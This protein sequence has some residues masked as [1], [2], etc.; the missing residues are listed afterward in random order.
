MSFK[1]L[2]DRFPPADRQE[3]MPLQELLTVVVRSVGERTTGAC[4]NLLS[5]LVPSEQIILVREVPFSRAMRRG[6]EAALE[7]GRKWTLVVDADTLV[8]PGFAQEITLFAQ[9]QQA[10]AFVVQGVVFDKFFNLLRPAGNHLYRT[11]HLQ[12]ALECI[13]EEGCTLRPETHMIG[14]MVR[15]GYLFIQKPFLAGLHDFEQQYLDIARKCFL[16]AHKHEPHWLEP[17]LPVW[18]RR[19]AADK[20]YVAALAGI[21]AGRAHRGAVFVNADFLEQQVASALDA[22]QLGAKSRLTRDAWPAVRVA[23]ACRDWL[24]DPECERMQPIMFPLEFW[25]RLE[26]MGSQR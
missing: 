12:K 16:H 17:I 8:L 1:G 3:A 5:T 14:E 6:F 20:D 22:T 15:R 7:L 9:R 11:R 2:G 10:N 24:A 26:G 4:L 13:P 18:Q 23:Q 21:A 25:D 19:Q